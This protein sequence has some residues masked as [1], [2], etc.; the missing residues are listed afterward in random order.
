MGRAM[1]VADPPQ[2]AQHRSPL[3]NGISVSARHG[4]SRLAMFSTLHLRTP[5][6]A[7][8]ACSTF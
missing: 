5:A 3:G 8:Q 7:G 2:G 6:T 4:V 1:I